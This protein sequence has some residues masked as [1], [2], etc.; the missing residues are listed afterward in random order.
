MKGFLSTFLIQYF[1]LNWD[2]MFIQGVLPG[3]LVQNNAYRMVM[4][5][6]KTKL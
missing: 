1:L 4:S 3:A 5:R 2:G 6:I